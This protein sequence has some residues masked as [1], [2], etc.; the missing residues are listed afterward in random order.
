MTLRIFGQ[1]SAAMIFLFPIVAHAEIGLR[2]M[3]LGKLSP[4]LSRQDE[5]VGTE[6]KW[7]KVQ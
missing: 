1:L 2:V 6:K 3:S 4:G 7:S 5:E